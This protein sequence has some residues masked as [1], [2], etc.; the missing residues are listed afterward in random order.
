M[1]RQ[2]GGTVVKIT[3]H[4]TTYTPQTTGHSVLN[5]NHTTQTGTFYDHNAV[6]TQ[7]HTTTVQPRSTTAIW[8]AT[9]SRR[10]G[11]GARVIRG[12]RIWKQRHYCGKQDYEHAQEVELRYQPSN[13]GPTRSGGTTVVSSYHQ[14]SEQ[15]KNKNDSCCHAARNLFNI[16]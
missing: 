4:H 11:S 12:S 3:Q 6:M 5:R 14:D 7:N 10:C 9:C 1:S 13:S 2:M 16:S 15:A 8:T